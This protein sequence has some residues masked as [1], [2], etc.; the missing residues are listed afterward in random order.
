MKGKDLIK[1]IQDNKAEDL[2]VLIDLSGDGPEL[3]TCIR[4]KLIDRSNSNTVIKYNTDTN[5]GYVGMAE[6]LGLGYTS[7]LEEN[8]MLIYKFISL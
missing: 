3:Y 6:S 8:E 1:W 2:D 4:P 5:Y 7:E